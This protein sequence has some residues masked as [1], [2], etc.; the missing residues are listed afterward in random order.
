[1]SDVRIID[2]LAEDPPAATDASHMSVAGGGELP[3]P[4]VRGLPATEAIEAV[5]AHGFIAAVQST[6]AEHNG[7]NGLVLDQDPPAGAMSAREGIV[8]LT[9]AEPTP[10]AAAA[11]EKPQAPP[12]D[13]EAGET[14]G[15]EDDTEEWF[16][17]LREQT[18]HPHIDHDALA[19]GETEPAADADEGDEDLAFDPDLDLDG[20]LAGASRRR[21]DVGDL[22]APLRAAVAVGVSSWRSWRWRAP[23]TVAVCVALGMLAGGTLEGHT[24]QSVTARVT[25]AHGKENPGS[26]AVTPRHASRPP[27]R[28]MVAVLRRRA[29]AAT[30]R[31]RVLV[32]REPPPQPPPPQTGAPPPPRPAQGAAV[33]LGFER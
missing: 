14:A 16:Q 12:K 7:E 4:D 32:V 3:V 10:Q 30:P 18:H 2:P 33:E 23:V 22:L 9:I 21:P 31:V 11:V 13:G 27:V 15:F 20:V 26:A 17:A 25:P 8:T 1:M 19:A 29:A 24:S 28:H 6:P 5:R